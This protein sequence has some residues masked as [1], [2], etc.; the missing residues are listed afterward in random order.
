MSS[1]KSE[2]NKKEKENLQYSSDKTW[3]KTSEAFN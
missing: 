2:E 1:E 3:I